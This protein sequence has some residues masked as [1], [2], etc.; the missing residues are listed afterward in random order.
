MSELVTARRTQ[1][2]RRNGIRRTANL[3]G[4]ERLLSLAAAAGAAALARR[5][6]PWLL[7]A[8]LV[9]SGAALLYRGATGRSAVY[10][11]L[12]IDLSPR[13]RREGLSIERS[14]TILRP[15]REVYDHCR[16]LASWPAVVP[17][18]SVGLLRPGVWR[19]RVSEGP[20]SLVWD[21]RLIEERPATSFAWETVPGSALSHRG[22]VSLLD[23]PGGRGT[24]L[25][26]RLF[27]RPPWPALSLRAAPLL[28]RLTQ[29][30]LGHE[31]HRLEQLLEA[32]EI[33]SGAMRP[34]PLV[35]RAP[36]RL[37]STP[38]RTQE[39]NA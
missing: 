38:T 34:T 23:A 13:S 16:D 11:A 25:H 3:G 31:F 29:Y 24:E 19:W 28:R 35:G 1:T 32:G 9:T 15:R 2:L 14:V 33:A 4:G 39:V 7:R 36:R 22:E 12:G 21:A 37:L 5:P 30:Q 18:L 20:F 26:V 17:G 6:V 10:R 8:A 27:F